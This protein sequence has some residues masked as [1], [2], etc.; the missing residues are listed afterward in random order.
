MPP[1]AVLK[2]VVATMA[3]HRIF[4][5]RAPSKLLYFARRAMFWMINDLTLGVTPT[6]YKVA[7]LW[8]RINVKMKIHNVMKTP[9]GG[10]GDYIHGRSTQVSRH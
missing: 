5:Q 8:N 2:A 7:R 6:H 4:W 9:L 3:V 1:D 10:G